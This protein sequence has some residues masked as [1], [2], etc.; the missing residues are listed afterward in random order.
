MDIESIIAAAKRAQ[1][2]EDA[3]LGNCSRTWHV[4]FF[5]DGIHR[6]IDQDASEQRLSNVAPSSGYNC[7]STRK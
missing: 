5:F 4:G 6:N 2:A 1:Q 7:K 3:G